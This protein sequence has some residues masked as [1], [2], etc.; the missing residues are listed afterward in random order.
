MLLAACRERAPSPAPAASS[1][2][3]VAA[4][5]VAAPTVADPTVAAPTV[6]ASAPAPIVGPQTISAPADPDERFLATAAIASLAAVRRPLVRVGTFDA[7]LAAPEGKR[8][9][10]LA[11]ATAA[12]PVAHRR[13]LAFY[14]LARALG[15]RVVPVTA[16]RHLGTGELAAAAEGSAE[17]AAALREARV[18]NDGTVDALLTARG[19]AHTGSAW[20]AP[21]ARPIE[22]EH[23]RETATW[24]VWARSAEPAP[25]ED[26]G[27]L[28]DY[29]EMLV[30]DYLSANVAR[31]Q[32][33]VVSGERRA[34]VLAD[35]ASAFPWR[36]E[37]SVLDKML[38][39]LRGVERFPRGLREALLAFDR[40]R[41]DATFAEGGFETWV[42][43]PRVRV[44]L[45]ERRAALLTLIEARI[46][47]R[48]AAAVLCL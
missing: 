40:A 39:R 27:L 41:A 12:D 26:A 43:P 46:A 28:R 19:T 34:L 5:T 31:R 24:E 13:P 1:A 37:A 22:P 33:L 15:A 8:A 25:G 38:R 4:A 42:L 35:N 2:A 17:A 3:I 14:R 32:A 18:L 29:V 6:S 30:L 11:I 47:V 16:L 44:E 36:P 7:V 23:A 9:A 21:A 45:D 10:T 48:G 20:Q